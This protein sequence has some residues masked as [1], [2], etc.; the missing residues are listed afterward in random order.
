MKI[1][2][3]PAVFALIGSGTAQLTASPC[4][5]ITTGVFRSERLGM[6]FVST[7]EALQWA[8][9]NGTEL[10]FIKQ[11]LDLRTAPVATNKFNCGVLNVTTTAAIQVRLVRHC[12]RLCLKSFLLLAPQATSAGAS[13]PLKVLLRLS[14]LPAQRHAA[15]YCAGKQHNAVWV[16]S[17]V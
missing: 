6:E 16:S 5:T 11:D 10:I 7:P 14:A 9:G 1:R 12:V 17:L 15:H 4:T 13:A 2:L 3:I 8:V